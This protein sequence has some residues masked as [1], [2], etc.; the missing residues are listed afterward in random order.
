VPQC[1]PNTIII[2]IIIKEIDDVP[3]AGRAER[4]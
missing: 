2:I 1:T 3:G 4:F